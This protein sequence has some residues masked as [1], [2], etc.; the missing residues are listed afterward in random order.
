MS[1]KII[2]RRGLAEVHANLV[3]TANAKITIRIASRGIDGALHGHVHGAELRIGVLRNGPLVIGRVQQEDELHEGLRTRQ[4]GEREYASGNSERWLT[5][6]Q[7]EAKYAPA[8]R[9][10]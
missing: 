10:R 2:H 9:P 7:E 1:I 4:R 6:G 5:V 3:V 8:G